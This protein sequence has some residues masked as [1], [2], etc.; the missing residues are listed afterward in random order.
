MR[1]VPL[2]CTAHPACRVGNRQ[3]PGR[4]L[5]RQPGM[6]VHTLDTEDAS[7]EGEHWMRGVAMQGA[8][9]RVTR[10]GGWPCGAARRPPAISAAAANTT[11]S[12]RERQCVC[13][14]FSMRTTRNLLACL[15]TSLPEYRPCRRGGPC[16]PCR[17]CP[18]GAPAVLPSGWVS[19]VGTGF[20]ALVL[21][22][23][24]AL[25]VF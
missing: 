23:F 3:L 9:C 4:L 2:Y 22:F 7:R 21:W 6:G 13:V 14:S 18:P 17:S 24:G 25:V 20:G 8:G 11:M 10:C 5:G 19:W 12:V 15:L 16:R 1:E